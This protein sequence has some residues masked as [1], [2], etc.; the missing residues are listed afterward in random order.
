MM[1]RQL[2]LLLATAMYMNLGCFFL[3][4]RSE[5]RHVEIL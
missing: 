1:S 3:V 5:R 4:V 2:K